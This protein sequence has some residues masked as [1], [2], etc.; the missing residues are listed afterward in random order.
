MARCS[1]NRLVQ[2]AFHAV[3]SSSV[4][5]LCSRGVATRGISGYIPPKSVYL[6]FFMWLFC[7]LDPGQIHLYPPK[8]NSWLRLCSAVYVPRCGEPRSVRADNLISVGRI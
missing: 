7:L 8:S 4:I 1:R 5:D 6:N 2:L 3:L